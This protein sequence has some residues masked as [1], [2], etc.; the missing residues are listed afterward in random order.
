MG[1]PGVTQRNEQSCGGHYV[2]PLVEEGGEGEGGNFD[3]GSWTGFDYVY[4]LIDS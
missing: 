3:E 1:R 2:L 4:T